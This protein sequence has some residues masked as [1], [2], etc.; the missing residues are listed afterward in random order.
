VVAPGSSGAAA[1]DTTVHPFASP[2]F[3]ENMVLQPAYLAPLQASH[4]LERNGLTKSTGHTITELSVLEKQLE[5]IRHQGSAVDSDV[6]M[7]FPASAV[8]FG[9][10]EASWWGQSAPRCLRR[11]F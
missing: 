5:T 11:N 9:I 6:W 10:R 7:A 2:S 3:G 1:Q 4:A 8:P